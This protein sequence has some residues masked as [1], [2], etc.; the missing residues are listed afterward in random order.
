APAIVKVE[1]NRKSIQHL[2]GGIVK[3]IRVKDGDRVEGN[4]IVIVLDDTQARAAVAVLAQQADVYRAQEARLHAEREE[5]KSIQFPG[6]LVKRRDN[7]DV[8]MLLDTEQKQ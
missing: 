8:A 5:A 7:I 1:G 2:D 4:Q 3:E 6:D